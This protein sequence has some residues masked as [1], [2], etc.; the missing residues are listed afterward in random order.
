MLSR[1]G[2]VMNRPDRVR[3]RR[4]LLSPPALARSPSTTEDLPQ[5]TLDDDDP[6]RP[7]DRG[8]DSDDLKDAIGNWIEAAMVLEYAIKRGMSPA[9]L[10]PYFGSLS[11]KSYP[12]PEDLRGFTIVLFHAL[13]HANIAAP[14]DDVK[15][16]VALVMSWAAGAPVTPHAAVE[17]FTRADLLLYQIKTIAAARPVGPATTVPTG[18]TDA[19]SALLTDE[20]RR[21]NPPRDQ[22]SEAPA[23]LSIILGG[24]GDEPIVC[25]KRKNPLPPAQY[26]VVKVLVEAKARGERLSKDAL[27]NRT[28]DERGNVIEDPVG[29]LERL[30]KRDPDWKRIIDM[31]KVP[32]RGYGLKDC[33]PTPTQKS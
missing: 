8:D 23:E 24:P 31:A 30:R 20:D 9:D 29:A 11:G 13:S 6:H 25:G 16:Y 5:L 17:A 26:R 27:S 18:V 4:F 32:G 2:G 33:P 14:M 7:D 15:D 12:D 22:G 1:M 10:P 3:C 28:K 21:L 19:A